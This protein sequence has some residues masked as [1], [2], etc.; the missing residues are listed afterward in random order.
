MGAKAMADTILNPAS[1][2]AKEQV[3]EKADKK[4]RMQ[5]GQGNMDQTRRKQGEVSLPPATGCPAH[6][7]Q[8][9]SK[10][11]GGVPERIPDTRNHWAS[12]A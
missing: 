8:P 12:R 10:A 5:Q 3:R 9:P 4:V 2:V 1:P 7:I 11:M 6:A